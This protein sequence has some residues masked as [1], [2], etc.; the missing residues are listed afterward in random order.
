MDTNR[1]QT[2]G[3][4]QRATGRVYLSLFKTFISIV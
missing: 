3:E 4:R 2:G 1:L